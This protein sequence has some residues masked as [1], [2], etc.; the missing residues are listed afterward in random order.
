M[1]DKAYPDEQSPFVFTGRNVNR[2][3]IVNAGSL[4]NFLGVVLVMQ[5]TSILGGRKV[6]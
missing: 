5:P 4:C 1:H 2:V 3:A 6:L